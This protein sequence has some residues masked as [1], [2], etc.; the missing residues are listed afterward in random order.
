VARCAAPVEPAHS[1]IAD[2]LGEFSALSQYE[3]GYQSAPNNVSAPP[4]VGRHNHQCHTMP[5][6][7]A[8][9]R[10]YTRRSRTGRSTF[11]TAVSTTLWKVDTS[12]HDLHQDYQ[13]P[14]HIGQGY[15]I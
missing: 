1:G 13:T 12:V 6:H 5:S 3:A 8:S 2:T 11:L 14:C 10:N 4:E 9:H 15:H 7:F